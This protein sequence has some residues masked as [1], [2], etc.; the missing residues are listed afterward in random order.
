MSDVP[1]RR[2]P[3]S[4]KMREV[5]EEILQEREYQEKRWGVEHDAKHT[6]QDWLVILTVWL[7]KLASTVHPYAFLDKQPNPS[8][9][10]KD[11][12]K[13]LIQVAAI[14]LAAVEAMDD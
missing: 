10:R 3:D 13:R 2:K 7:G 6:F 1:E 9:D 12:R 11:Y 14:C 4:A 8:Q 5:L